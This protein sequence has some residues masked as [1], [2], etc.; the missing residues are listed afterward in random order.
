MEIVKYDEKN[1]V[2]Y[3]KFNTK[4]VWKYAGIDSKL[5]KGIIDAEEPKKFLS[6]L[7][8]NF[9]LVGTYNEEL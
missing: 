7:I 8:H 6:Y 2:L 4:A 1:K 9:N 3:V 5:Y